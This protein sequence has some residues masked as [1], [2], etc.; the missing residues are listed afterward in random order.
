MEVAE[1][2]GAIASRRAE[3][4]RP[5][6]VGIS[7]Y[8][9]AGKS[10]LARNLLGLVPGSVRMRGDDFLDPSR[11]HRRSTDWDG[12]ERSRLVREVLGPF[13][14]RQPSMFR[15]FDWSARA[16]GDP[17]PIP[18]GEVLIVDLIGLFHP[19]AVGALDLTVWC[20]VDLAT[21]QRRGM[22][23][24][25]ALG[26][27]HSSLWNEVWVSNERDFDERFGPASAAEIRIP[28]P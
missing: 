17:E 12:V 13:R 6:V 15:R 20:D 5:I 23:R 2:A 4:G 10:T 1:L 3:R 16:L 22:R 18:T 8:G 25:S 28:M 7:G 27:D 14:D 11:S 26:R 24:D 21:A 9:G 19:E